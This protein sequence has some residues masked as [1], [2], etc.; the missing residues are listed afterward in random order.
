VISLAILVLAPTFDEI[1]H[2]TW[3]ISQPLLA[4]Q[5]YRANIA[6]KDRSIGA[7]RK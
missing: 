5:Q 6:Q 3:L 1:G 4:K 7:A 2:Q